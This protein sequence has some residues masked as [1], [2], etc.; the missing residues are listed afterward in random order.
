MKPHNS[1]ALVLFFVICG[2]LVSASPSSYASEHH[3]RG[4]LIIKRSPILPHNVTITLRLDGRVAGTLV[5]GQ[6]FDQSVTPGHHV[7][8]AS[9]NKQRGD[10]RGNLDVR[11]GH[12]YSYVASYN[13]NRVV[14]SPA[15]TH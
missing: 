14:L 15:K 1:R 10:W 12:T 9:P 8:E 2:L 6:V 4:R 3:D 13:V 7:L 5:R 11:P